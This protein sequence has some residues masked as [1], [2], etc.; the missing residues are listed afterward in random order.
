MGGSHTGRRAR[1]CE[2]GT[3]A[4]VTLMAIGCLVHRGQVSGLLHE[5]EASGRHA[6]PAIKGSTVLA[7]KTQDGSQVSSAKK[8]Q[9]SGSRIKRQASEEETT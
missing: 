8:L 3:V 4:F 2:R 1:M 5:G 7:D 6:S 9:T